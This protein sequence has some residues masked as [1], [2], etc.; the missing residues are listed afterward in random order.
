MMV[1]D[2]ALIAE[3]SLY[4]YGFV[5]VSIRI[6]VSF[7]SKTYTT[8]SQSGHV[9]SPQMHQQDRDKNM[10][11]KT[12]SRVFNRHRERMSGQRKI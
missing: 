7:F 6:F 3:I 10:V 12:F 2:Y 11:A 1:P 8:T 5:N 9:D 4:S